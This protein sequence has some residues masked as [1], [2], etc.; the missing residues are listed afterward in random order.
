MM[1]MFTLLVSDVLIDDDSESNNMF[2]SYNINIIRS[3]T[4]FGVL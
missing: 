2:D 3:H 4:I 1:S